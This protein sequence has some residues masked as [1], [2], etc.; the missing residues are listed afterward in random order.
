VCLCFLGDGATN[1]GAFH[2]GLNL[3]GLWKLPVIYIIENNKYGMGTSV[4]RAS[5]V[6]DLY[7]KAY[8]YNIRSEVV[9]GMDVLEV[10][11]KVKAAVDHARATYEPTLLEIETY[12]Y[13]GHSM[14]DPVHGHYRS[15]EE[16]ERLKQSD[17]IIHFAE[18]LK[19]EGMISDQYLDEAEERIKNIVQ[20]CVEFAENSP[21][22]P[23]DELWKDVTIEGSGE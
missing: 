18:T 21:E 11:Q 16:V 1:I 12:R 3:A 4:E 19:E 7:K 5:A 14:S 13:R 23:I 8:A 10:Y 15:K 6:E 2:E 20:E 9:N 22:P 17:P